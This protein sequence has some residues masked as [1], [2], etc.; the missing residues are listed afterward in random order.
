ME[1]D[2]YVGSV[3]KFDGISVFLV[4]Y[5]GVFDGDF[6]LEILEVNYGCK[7][8]NGCEEVYNV[9]KMVVVEGFF[10]GV[11]FVVLSE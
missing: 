1:Y 7:D 4:F 6:D 5:F 3:E 9:W 8:S 2:R 10:E 11:S